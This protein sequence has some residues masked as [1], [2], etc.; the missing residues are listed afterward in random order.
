MKSYYL[1]IL[2]WIGSL[3]YTNAQII[4]GKIMDI[5]TGKAIQNVN[6]FLD[7]TLI[8]TTSNEFGK[9]QLNIQGNINIPLIFSHVGFESVILTS[10]DF[11]K[12]LIVNLINKKEM[13]DEIE[14]KSS[15]SSW[16][17]KKMLNTFKKNF[18]GTSEYA[19]S[20]KILNED[21]IYLYYNDKTKTLY[22]NSKNPIIII[23]KLLG[24][25]IK[26]TLNNFYYSLDSIKYSGFQF[27]EDFGLRNIKSIQ[28]NRQDVYKGSILHFM[29]FLHDNIITDPDT[30]YDIRL[31]TSSN[32]YLRENIQVIVEKDKKQDFKLENLDTTNMGLPLDFR[33]EPIF[34]Q[35]HLHD[36]FGN[37][38]T[39][40]VVL[41]EDINGNKYL[42]YQDKIRVLFYPKFMSSYLY[43][44]VDSVKIE[45]NGYYNPK[46]ISWSG[47]ISKKRVGDQLPYDYEFPRK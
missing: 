20:C 44:K 11:N 10:F 16:S 47:S 38:L 31:V 8:G 14:V 23:N 39:K 33:P 43:P 45:K 7:G 29:R 22:G 37:Y 19:Q 3:F 4:S 35:F 26:Y 13:I 6:I 15:P 25:K 1:L 42:C 21:D 34:E 41:R 40:K 18:L 46:E 12:Q 5:E 36:Q 17:R 27:F 30:V 28:K 9:F 2:V 24:Y 32:Y